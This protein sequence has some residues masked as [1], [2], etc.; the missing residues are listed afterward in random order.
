MHA[1]CKYLYT[2]YICL[3]LVYNESSI[4]ANMSKYGS[5]LSML[6]ACLYMLACKHYVLYSCT[7]VHMH[8]RMCTC[9]YI[10]SYPYIHICMH[11]CMYVHTHTH[12]HTRIDTHIRTLARA[13]LAQGAAGRRRWIDIDMHLWLLAADCAA[14]KCGN[15]AGA[16]GAAGPLPR[17]IC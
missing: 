1:V 8:I 2:I 6:Y 5:C 3:F 4:Y 7:Y 12:T 10:H 14:G 17:Q 11:V 9:M 16:G 15:G 13:A